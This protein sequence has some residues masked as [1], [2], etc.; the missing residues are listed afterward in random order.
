VARWTTEQDRTQEEHGDVERNDVRQGSGRLL[1]VLLALVVLTAVVVAA[2]VALADPPRWQVTERGIVLTEQ[3]SARQ[4]GVELVFVALGATASLVWGGLV[5]GVL[6][7]LGW[8]TVPLACVGTLLASLGAWRLGVL[9][10]PDGPRA[11]VD[12]RLGQEILAQLAVDSPAAFLVWPIA[13]L[14]G[15]LLVTWATD[16]R[17]AISERSDPAPLR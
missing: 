4:L 10:G 8:A 2:W 12:P 7:H 13:A 5:G 16:R 17:P 14:V 6:R 15:L 11:A 1:L 3:A 9:L